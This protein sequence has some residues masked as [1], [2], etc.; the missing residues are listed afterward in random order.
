MTE[1]RAILVTGSSRGIG[2]YLCETWLERGWRV[3]GCSRGESDLKHP[4]YH[5]FS[6][7]VSDERSVV[8]MFRKI[9]KERVPLWALINNAGAASMN[10]VMTT[11]A[12]TMVKL[13]DVNVIGTMLCSREAVKVMLASKRGR[14]VNFSTIACAL[15][16]EGE[17]VYVASKG[18]VE[19]YT[20]VL[21][22]EV[23]PLGITVN[24]VAPN[25]IRTALIAG[26]PDDKIQKIIDRQAIRRYGE[27]DDVLRVIDFYVNE[28]N[29]LITGQSIY[30]GGP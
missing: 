25:P 8:R 27:F 29:S 22:R 13:L 12:S 26:V 2:R 5:H 15:D 3:Y 14:I 6:L 24:L 18:A 23:G 10:H 19:A 9:R 16:L 1:Q 30:L 28:Q 21:A 20:R 4:E 11:P 17:A 7:S